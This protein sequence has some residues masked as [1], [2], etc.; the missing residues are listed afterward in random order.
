[1]M[2]TVDPLGEHPDSYPGGL[3]DNGGVD[4]EWDCILDS[5]TPDRVGRVT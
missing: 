2:V 3:D 1:M 4:R 5:R